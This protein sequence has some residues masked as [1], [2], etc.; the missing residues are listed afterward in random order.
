[1]AAKLAGVLNE[2]HAE[3][4]L[5]SKLLA[6]LIGR[7]LLHKVKRENKRLQ[8]KWTYEPPTFYEKN[9]PASVQ[10]HQPHSRLAP[11]KLAAAVALATVTR[12]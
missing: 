10:V 8:A 6:P 7:Y 3:F 9:A 11:A 12:H 5:K 2:V 4:G 1:M